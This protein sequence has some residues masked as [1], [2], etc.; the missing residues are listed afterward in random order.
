[1]SLK[2]YNLSMSFF[3][4]AR[5]NCQRI[6]FSQ[7]TRLLSVLVRLLKNGRTKGT[8]G[9]GTQRE[10]M[11]AASERIN[12]H[13]TCTE[14]RDIEHIAA[15]GTDSPHVVRFLRAASGNEGKQKVSF[16]RQYVFLEDHP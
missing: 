2:G 1:M 11:N 15:V 8:K 7:I 5:M 13:S 16:G 3:G 6:C 12:R 9:P 10:D 14:E 4:Q